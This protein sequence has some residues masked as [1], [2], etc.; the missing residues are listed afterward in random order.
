MTG[1]PI[2]WQAVRDRLE[3]A[4][5]AIE[6][7]GHRSPEQARRVLEERA[8]SLAALPPATSA[9]EGQDLLVFTRE[10]GRYGLEPSLAIEL[11]PGAVPTPVPG[12]PPALTGVVNYR[13]EVLAVVD[14]RGF[15]GDAARGGRRDEATGRILVVETAGTRLGIR[16][17]D[18]QGIVRVPA[19][20]LTPAGEG[21][22]LP[23]WIR[24]TTGGMVAVVDVE[25]LVRDPRVTVEEMDDRRSR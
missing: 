15:A 4:A 9:G 17:D 23:S 20:E 6:R 12:A 8:Q 7:G 10:G 2:D 21:T 25:A 18:V 19:G 11:L 24:G 13:G 3:Q 22:G 5:R 1:Q 14:L 16:A